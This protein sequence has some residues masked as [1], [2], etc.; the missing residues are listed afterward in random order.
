M[1][2]YITSSSIIKQKGDCRCAVLFYLCFSLCD[3][4]RDAYKGDTTRMPESLTAA[5]YSKNLLSINDDKDTDVYHEL[6]IGENELVE[7][8][9]DF[10]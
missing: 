3:V 2:S 6:V 10:E 5:T 9:T 8:F 4:V 7:N 1:N